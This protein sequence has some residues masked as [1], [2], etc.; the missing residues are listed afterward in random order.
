[1][2]YFKVAFVWRYWGKPW[3]A[4]NNQP[5]D[6]ESNLGP[7]HHL[8]HFIFT[9]HIYLFIYLF[10]Y[11]QFYDFEDVCFCRSSVYYCNDQ[12]IWIFT[13]CCHW[14][15]P[16]NIWGWTE[17]ESIARLHKRF[18]RRTKLLSHAATTSC[19]VPGSLSSNG[20]CLILYLLWSDLVMIKSSNSLFFC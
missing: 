4:Q 7:P 12:V 20:W 8:W 11:F 6:W 18:K 16:E 15:E 14:W 3:K 10:I 2:A 13:G 17:S 1:M 19:S 5:L 9:Q